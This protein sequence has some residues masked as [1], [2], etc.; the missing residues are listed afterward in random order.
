[1]NRIHSYY[2][3]GVPVATSLIETATRTYWIHPLDECDG[4]SKAV[5]NDPAEDFVPAALKIQ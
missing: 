5:S 4:C 2:P 1:M 3:I